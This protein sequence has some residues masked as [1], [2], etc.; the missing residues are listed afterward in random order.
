[1]AKCNYSLKLINNATFEK[2]VEDFARFTAPDFRE[3]AIKITDDDYD[4]YRALNNVRAHIEGNTVVFSV[5]YDHL[6]VQ[7][8]KQ[9]KAFSQYCDYCELI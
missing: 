7:I 3:G 6:I 5:R 9:I 4:V 1:M 8:D 2:V